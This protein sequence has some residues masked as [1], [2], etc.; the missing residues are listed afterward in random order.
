VT[1]WL[2]TN[3]AARRTSTSRQH[4]EHNTGKALTD[5]MASAESGRPFAALRY[6][7]DPI[8]PAGRLPQIGGTFGAANTKE[9]PGRLHST[10]V[11]DPDDSARQ[12]VLDLLD[13]VFGA[14][15]DA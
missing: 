5:V 14:T 3:R 7:N 12:R 8:C 11:Y 10:L 6:R 1:S 13:E 15:Q 4:A 9:I 2:F